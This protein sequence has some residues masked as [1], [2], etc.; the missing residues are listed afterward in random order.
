MTSLNY[1]VQ[2]DLNTMNMLIIQKKSKVTRYI[3]YAI[4][5]KFNVDFSHQRKVLSSGCNSRS[6]VVRDW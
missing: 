4:V 2:L 5:A 6:L 3:C 1:L